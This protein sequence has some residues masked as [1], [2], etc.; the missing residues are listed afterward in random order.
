[1]SALS[2]AA[3][4]VDAYSAISGTGATSAAELAKRGK[5]KET[6]QKFEASFL[7]SMMQSMFEG[8]KT[9]EPFGGGQ[10]EEMFK[11][12]LTDAMAK[13]VAKAGGVGIAASVQREMLKMQGLQ[14]VAQ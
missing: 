11:S 9:P 10:G 1:M 4:A 14:E 5:I 13:E 12:L 7:S 8:V 3:S 2:S 6:A